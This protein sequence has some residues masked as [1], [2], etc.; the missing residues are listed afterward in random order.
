MLLQDYL[1]RK[2]GVHTTTLILIDSSSGSVINFQG[3]EN[4]PKDPKGASFPWRYPKCSDILGSSSGHL[5]TSANG[6]TN[7]TH[8]SSSSTKHQV[9]N[10]SQ[11]NGFIKGFYFAAYWVSY[12]KSMI[13][14]YKVRCKENH[15]KRI[16]VQN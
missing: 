6:N 13:K 15:V 12:S 3:V 2:F 5:I 10:A 8:P 9:V 7:V 11:L 1:I 4:I 14:R 16:F